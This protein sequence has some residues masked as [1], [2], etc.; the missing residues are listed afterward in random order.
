[1]MLKLETVSDSGNLNR[2]REQKQQEKQDRSDAIPSTGFWH[3]R[4]GL[5]MI[6]R[7]VNIVIVVRLQASMPGRPQYRANSANSGTP[8]STDSK[9]SPGVSKWSDVKTNILV[10]KY[11]LFPS[12]DCDPAAI[13]AAL[14]STNTEWLKRPGYALS[15]FGQDLKEFMESFPMMTTFLNGQLV[16]EVLVPLRDAIQRST[17]EKLIQPIGNTVTTFADDEIENDPRAVGRSVLQLSKELLKWS[18]CRPEHHIESQGMRVELE[19][20]LKSLAPLTNFIVDILVYLSIVENGES[21]VA[22]GEGELATNETF[23]ALKQTDA[24]PT[25]MCNYFAQI[26]LKHCEHRIN[27]RTLTKIGTG[28]RTLTTAFGA[29]PTQGDAA[30]STVPKRRRILPSQA[31]T[32]LGDMSMDNIE[33]ESENGEEDEVVID[34]DESPVVGTSS[35]TA[36]ASG[37]STVEELLANL[38]A[39]GKKTVRNMAR[40]EGVTVRT[41]LE[42]QLEVMRGPAKKTQWTRKIRVTLNRAKDEKNII[43]VWII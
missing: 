35:V 9:K 23:N 22:K 21:Y 13:A 5:G 8:S 25:D 34:L 20:L 43:V 41:I 37:P 31:F 14:A 33:S 18:K 39:A 26:G 2:S 28:R 38:D 15:F 7:L 29:T 32:A 42:R 24:R 12:V 10:Q 27:G 17:Y 4:R 40:M 1:M 16:A 3:G 6:C 30:P 36:V 11:G 19:Q